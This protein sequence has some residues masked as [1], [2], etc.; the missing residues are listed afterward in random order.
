MYVLS[1]V[2]K[3]KSFHIILYHLF[4]FSLYLICPS[5]HALEIGG[6]MTK[7]LPTPKQIG[8][9]FNRSSN[10]EPQHLGFYCYCQV[11]KKESICM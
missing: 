2:E 6:R 11:I 9:T 10:H 1:G 5:H 7:I 8:K 4:F 3:K